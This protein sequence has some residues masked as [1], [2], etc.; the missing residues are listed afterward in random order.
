VKNDY[1]MTPSQVSRVKIANCF[2][3]SILLASLVRRE[4]PAEDVHVVIGNLNQPDPG[5]HSWVQVFVDGNDYIM[6]STRGDMQPLISYHV[7]EIY[8]DIIHFNDRS[9]SVI[10]ARTLL[11]PFAD[12]YA[13]WLRDYL[14]W[15]FIEGRK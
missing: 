14:D 4:L 1:W 2:N 11:T 6:E 7:A 15:A 8:E 13:N 10:P 12:V 9:V 5:G 3:K